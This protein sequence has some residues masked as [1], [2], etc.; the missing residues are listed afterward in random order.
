MNFFVISLFQ[1]AGERGE[2]MGCNIVAMSVMMEEDGELEDD[3]YLLSCCLIIPY[4]S[5]G[6]ARAWQVRS[7]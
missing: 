3:S 7:A 4:I 6:I 2:G 5:P 1:L